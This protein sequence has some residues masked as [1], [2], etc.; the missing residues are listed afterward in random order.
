MKKGTARLNWP[1]DYEAPTIHHI[2]TAYQQALGVSYCSDGMSAGG[3]KQACANGITATGDTSQICA[4][5]GA[6]STTKP[7]SPSACTAGPGAVAPP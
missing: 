5:G 7:G 1:S 4:T 3:G 6:A 2:Q